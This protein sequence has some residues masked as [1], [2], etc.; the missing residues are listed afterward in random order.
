MIKVYRKPS[1]VEWDFNDVAAHL[2]E[3]GFLIGPA[4]IGT[5]LEAD[6][7]LVRVDVDA[8][9]PDDVLLAALDAY[10]PPADPVRQARA[11]LIKRGRAILAKEADKRTE[12]ETD[13]LALLTLVQLA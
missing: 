12:A 5:E 10:E 3:R 8:N 13:L 9:V 7:V 4:G 1:D 2:R 11:H 6:D